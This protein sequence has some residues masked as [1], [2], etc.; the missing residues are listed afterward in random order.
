MDERAESLA[1]VKGVNDLFYD[2]V[3]V[4]DQKATYI[5]TIIVFL[6]VWSPDVRR[7][8]FWRETDPHF[9]AMFFLSAVLIAA[10]LVALGSALLVVIPRRLKGGTVMFWGS[11]PQ[12][13][14]AALAIAASAD[15]DA[16]AKT[17]IDNAEKLAAICRSKYRFVSISFIALLIALAAHGAMIALS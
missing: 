6:L 11:W 16:L 14:E 7:L 3:K 9:S 17:Y 12:A 10:L 2:Q 5:M 13:R 1:Y 15:R 8:F 4:A